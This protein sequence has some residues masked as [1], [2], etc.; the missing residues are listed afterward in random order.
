MEKRIKFIDISRAIGI[1]LVVFGHC[2]IP[3]I[4]ESNQI[5]NSIYK[6]IYLF[7]M[8]LFFFISGY[9]FENNINKYM[10][11]KDFI[12]NK[13]RKLMIP[14]FVY[15]IFSYVVI[16]ICCRVKVLNTIL[17]ESGYEIKGIKES[18]IQIM[19]CNG[20]VD[21]HLW[22][23]FALFFVFLI[24]I[25]FSKKNNKKELLFSALIIWILVQSIGNNDYIPFIVEQILKGFLYFMIGRNSN[26]MLD[27]AMKCKFLGVISIIIFI[28]LTY[29]INASLIS[30][31]FL[32]TI[33]YIAIAN[34][35]IYMV[36]LLS[37]SIEKNKKISIIFERLSKYSFQIYLFHQPFI[38]SGI[39]GLAVKYTKL[40]LI[41]TIPIVVI[42]GIITPI[43]ITKFI[44]NKSNVLSILLLGKMGEGKKN[45]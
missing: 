8:P 32:R 13:F 1:L 36:L 4:R 30:S 10:D 22:F 18:L 2:I 42:I 33:I 23:L 31:S 11:K 26:N 20:N 15:S 17:I 40:K 19:T 39:M 24:N 9:I 37:K 34:L 6:I 38:V 45:E 12:K 5:L 3:N 16:Y 14:Y 28:F 29:M 21:K 43:F 44:L 27:K 35:G 41:I 7:H 25:V